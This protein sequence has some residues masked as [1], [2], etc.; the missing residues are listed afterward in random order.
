MLKLDRAAR[1]LARPSFAFLCSAVLVLFACSALSIAR[2]L[3][4]RAPD[5]PESSTQRENRDAPPQLE[6]E[7]K[8]IT[9]W[10]GERFVF[11]DRAPELRSY[12]YTNIYPAAESI[13]T[14]PYRDY[15]GKVVKITTVTPLSTSDSGS[16]RVDMI[17]EVTGERLSARSANGTVD[18]LGPM[19]DIERARSIYVG[20]TLWRA[21]GVL[22]TYDKDTGTTSFISIDPF[23]ALKVVAVMAGWYQW[24]PVRFVV[25]TP[26]RAEG[27][28]DVKMSGT[29]VTGSLRA[30]DKFKNEF[31]LVPP[32]K[33]SAAE[34]SRSYKPTTEALERAA[35]GNDVLGWQQSWWGMTTNEIVEAFGSALKRPQKSETY[36]GKYVEYLI[37][38]YR[39]DGNSY[40]VVFQMH[41]WNRRL[42]QILI[43]SNEEFSKDSP[44]TDV[45]NRLEALL[46]KKYG[47][48]RYKRDDDVL[49]YINRKR[50]WVFPTTSI[51]LDYSFSQGIE[52]TLTIRYYPTASSD[53]NKL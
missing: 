23:A 51:D 5:V 41:N 21:D 15:V 14:V 30:P 37:P 53:A 35:A 9:Q 22:R 34:A 44:S 47:P 17:V 16:Y 45:F 27:F 24:A 6:F 50:T 46:S 48:V 10:I 29:N 32:L 20:M 2:I 38:N 25:R 43:T 7:T 11:L 33:E 3:K 52:N 36:S 4:N 13:G 26:E 31:Q 8:P 1:L 19:A 28:V 42:A 18:G 49:D 39:V 12:P 40:T